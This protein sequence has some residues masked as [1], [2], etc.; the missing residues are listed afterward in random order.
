MVSR[1]RLSREEAESLHGVRPTTRGGGDIDVIEVWTKERFELWV[2]DTKL[3][4]GPNPYEFIPFVIFP[5]LQEPKQFWGTSELS[6]A[7]PETEFERWL[8]E[9]RRARD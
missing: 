4:D 2:G 7:D 6:V 5:N 3:E 1:Y 9:Q 8:E